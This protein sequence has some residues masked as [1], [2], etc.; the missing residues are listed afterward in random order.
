MI[1][2]N[3]HYLPL[4]TP[5]S[6]IKLKAEPQSEINALLEYVIILVVGMRVIEI[7]F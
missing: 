4:R 6:I 1:P 3:I 7:Q 5:I 2:S